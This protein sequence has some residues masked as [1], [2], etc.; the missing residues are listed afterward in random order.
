[1]ITTYTFQPDGT[2]LGKEVDAASYALEDTLSR[3]SQGIC[4][5]MPKEDYSEGAQF[6]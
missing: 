5:E 3:V 4:H 2:F 6:D 1:M